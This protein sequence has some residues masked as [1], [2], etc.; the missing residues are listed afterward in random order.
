[1]GQAPTCAKATMY[2]VLREVVE[3]KSSGKKGVEMVAGL[4]IGFVWVCEHG[5]G[6]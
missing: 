4:S 6:R 3:T 5:K 1:M 2:K